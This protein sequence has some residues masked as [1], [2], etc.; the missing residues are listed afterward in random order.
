MQCSAR[1]ALAASIF[2]GRKNVGSVGMAKA[3]RLVRGHRPSLNGM[4]IR[5]QRSRVWTNQAFGLKNPPVF[6]HGNDSQAFVW[7]QIKLYI[8]I[9][10]NEPFPPLDQSP[11]DQSPCG[12]PAH[13][14]LPPR[15]ATLLP[16]A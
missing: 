10:H 2:C 8:F 1:A 12:A 4:K 16:L 14:P 7:I 11:P 5:K 13:G 15:A 6:G 3:N 9:A